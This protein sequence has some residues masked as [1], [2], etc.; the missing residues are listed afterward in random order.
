MHDLIKRNAPRGV[1]EDTAW[2]L[3]LQSALGLAHIHGLK[4]LHRDV[5]SENIFLDA[6]GDAKIGDLGVAKSLK[7]T[8]DLGVTLVGTP[9]YLSPEL[10][11]RRPYDAKSDVW[12]L[13]VVL[14]ELLTGK[15]PFRA[16]SQQ[17]LFLKILDGSYAPL[18]EKERGSSSGVSRDMRLLVR[19]MLETNVS[20]RVD[21]AGVATRPASVAKAR[22]LGVDGVFEALNID[23]TVDDATQRAVRGTNDSEA[24]RKNVKNADRPRTAAASRGLRLGIYTTDARGN[25]RPSTTRAGLRAEALA[26]AERLARENESRSREPF[27][28]REDETSNVSP[29]GKRDDSDPDPARNGNGNGNERRKDW[30]LFVAGRSPAIAAG[31]AAAAAG[32][33]A[34]GE[35][36]AARHLTASPRFVTNDPVAAAAAATAAQARAARQRAIEQASEA[37]RE[38]ERARERE[39]QER[40]D[41]NEEAAARQRRKVADAA[42]AS[43]AAR[44]RLASARARRVALSRGVG[45]SPTRIGHAAVSASRPETACAFSSDRPD[46]GPA[47]GREAAMAAA[48]RSRAHSARPSRPNASEGEEYSSARLLAAEA[49]DAA[50]AVA[51]LP[52]HHHVASGFFAHGPKAAFEQ[53]VEDAKLASRRV[54][55]MRDGG[56]FAQNPARNHSARPST[57]AGCFRVPKH[58]EGGEHSRECE[59]GKRSEY[60]A[61]VRPLWP[62]RPS[63]AAARVGPGELS[64]AVS[65][66][67][68]KRGAPFVRPS[69]AAALRRAAALCAEIENGSDT[70]GSDAV[71]AKGNKPAALLAV[72]TALAPLS[73]V[74]ESPA[75]AYAAASP[76]SWFAPVGGDETFASS[77]KG[78]PYGGRLTVAPTTADETCGETPSDADAFSG[79]LDDGGDAFE[80]ALRLC[81]SAAET[82]A[83]VAERLRAREPPE[84]DGSRARTVAEDDGGVAAESEEDLNASEMQDE[85]I[86]HETRSGDENDVPSPSVFPNARD[87]VAIASSSPPRSPSR[88]GSAFGERSVR[89]SL[90]RFQ[91]RRSATCFEPRVLTPSRPLT[92]NHC[93]KDDSEEEDGAVVEAILE[94]LL[95]ES[96]EAGSVVETPGA[97]EDESVEKTVASVHESERDAA[98]DDDERAARVEALVAEMSATESSGSALIGAE[99]FGGLYDA[100]ARR[101]EAAA[102]AAAAMHLSSD[103]FNRAPFGTEEDGESESE[104]DERS[105][106]SSDAESDGSG[107]SRWTPTKRNVFSEK[108][109]RDET[110]SA[111]LGPFA[112]SVTVAMTPRREKDGTKKKAK[113]RRDGDDV[114]LRFAQAEVLALRYARLVSELEKVGRSREGTPE[115]DNRD[116]ALGLAAGGPTGK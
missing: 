39:R 6:K 2:R 53:G 8:N 70:N 87:A 60:S 114:T 22:A 11:D 1:S 95:L 74:E 82:A 94:A 44:A 110:W 50:A 113:R 102:A 76:S 73:D 5:K 16:R 66:F 25:P 24:L 97:E 104:S 77:T 19:D 40:R 41:A 32:G 89:S 80:R 23:G 98:A 88:P 47:S 28:L 10:C 59:D 58:P 14:Y 71:S 13:G 55:A 103:G 83:G 29:S 45:G 21:A 17:E 61:P 26:E 54:D 93:E 62:S 42:E 31:I 99:A 35:A 96:A 30:E 51:A 91:R 52:E 20:R 108:N 38:R 36:A 109:A 90:E 56:Y 7:N 86:Q 46:R 84:G 27:S 115:G 85:F 78:Y 111:T 92:L 81:H 15:P 9:F 63:T 12:S 106:D 48:G 69:S 112:S 75:G 57:A 18:P 3:I 49:R 105:F 72:D 33:G 107:C 64:G 67:G 79:A 37:R 68:Q 116:C 65:G 101:A 100:L 43:A 4:I 34:A